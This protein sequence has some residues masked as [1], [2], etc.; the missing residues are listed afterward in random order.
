MA[1]GCINS[2]IGSKKIGLWLTDDLV[3]K[4]KP[5]APFLILQQLAGQNPGFLLLS[6]MGRQGHFSVKPTSTDGGW[7]DDPT[8]YF[9]IDEMRRSIPEDATLSVIRRIHSVQ[10]ENQEIDP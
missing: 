3:W 1:S 9:R 4:R 7:P 6:D 5:P 2:I 8:D 10:L